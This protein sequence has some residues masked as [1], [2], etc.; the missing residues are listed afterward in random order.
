MTQCC[1]HPFRSSCG[2][3]CMSRGVYLPKQCQRQLVWS[4]TDVTKHS[5][6]CPIIYVVV[7]SILLAS[8]LST[9][10]ERCASGESPLNIAPCYGG[11]TS[12]TCRMR[13]VERHV[14]TVHVFD[15]MTSSNESISAWLALCAGNSPVTGEFPAQRP[16]VRSFDDWVYNREA[17]N[18]RHNRDHYDVT[19]MEN[20][21]MKSSLIQHIAASSDERPGS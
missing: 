3:W 17:G 1:W 19:V 8:M 13:Y 12:T 10:R 15:M 7:Q 2:A 9:C 6:P 4:R 5:G 18:W 14:D 20:A 11:R 16:V 21:S